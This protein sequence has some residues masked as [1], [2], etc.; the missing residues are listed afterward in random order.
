MQPNDVRLRLGEHFCIWRPSSHACVWA[1]PP[2]TATTP[3]IVMV[4]DEG[5]IGWSLV[6][7]LILNSMRLLW[8]RDPLHKQCRIYIRSISATPLFY[9]SV[10]SCLTIFKCRVCPFGSSKLLRQMKESLIRFLKKS[11][12]SHTIYDFFS[13]SILADHGLK[14]DIL[15]TRP[16]RV[17]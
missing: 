1:L 14:P 10:A 8:H 7:F 6:Q 11:D 9:A 13:V 4:G 12:S 15:H 16:Q 5:A 17:Q 2:C 3:F